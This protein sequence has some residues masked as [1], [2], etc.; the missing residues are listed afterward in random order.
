MT[1]LS[2]SSPHAAWPRIRRRWS[3]SGTP[4]CC[5]GACWWSS[6]M[7][8]NKPHPWM[9]QVAG[10]RSYVLITGRRPWPQCQGDPD[11]A[12]RLLG[13]G[14]WPRTTQIATPMTVEGGMW[15]DHQ[16]VPH[17]IAV[18]LKTAKVDGFAAMPQAEMTRVCSCFRFRIKAVIE[19]EAD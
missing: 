6:H 3:F 10:G 11:L 7:L 9:D 8:C 18:F 14:V 5:G 1:S 4:Q 19:A 13:E 2:A 16:Q 17:K 15:E 12:D